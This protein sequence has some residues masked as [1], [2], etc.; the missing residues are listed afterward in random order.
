MP[1][2][3]KLATTKWTKDLAYKLMN[4]VYDINSNSVLGR[5]L[6]AIISKE[7]TSLADIFKFI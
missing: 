1:A 6:R 4:Q 7:G 2:T 5:N 3:Q